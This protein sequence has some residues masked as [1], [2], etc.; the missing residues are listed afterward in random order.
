MTR[1]CTGELR[2]P[3]FIPG[4]SKIFFSPPKVSRP[5]LGTTQL[6]SLKW[7]PGV[8]PGL[9]WL[10]SEADHLIPT[11]TEIRNVRSCTSTPLVPLWQACGHLYLYVNG[12]N[13]N[14]A[15]NF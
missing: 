7:V 11:C 10:G 8:F 9:K 1:L 14:F 5:A 2:N 3:G 12:C 15:D 6:P 13:T 4:R